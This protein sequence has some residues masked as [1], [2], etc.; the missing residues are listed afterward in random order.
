MQT[1]GSNGLFREEN[2]DGSCCCWYPNR[3]NECKPRRS[4]T[5]GMQRQHILVY[6]AALDDPLATGLDSQI[7]FQ[8][9]PGFDMSESG[10]T[11]LGTTAVSM[12]KPHGEV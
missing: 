9:Y 3:P 7:N 8:S 6:L 4:P 12:K 11:D 1:F 10:F 5:P 2:A